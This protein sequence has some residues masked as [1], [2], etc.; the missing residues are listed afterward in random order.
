MLLT[1]VKIENFRGIRKLELGLGETTVLIGE[2]NTG[3]TSILEALHI[4]LSRGLGGRTVPFSEYD[5]HL[6]SPGRDPADAPPI[7]I[8]LTF[9]EQAKDEWSDE[10]TRALGEV[11]QI[12]DDDRQSLMLRITCVY[13]KAVR[14][15]VADWVFLNRE[16]DELPHKQRKLVT[17][18][19][20]LAPVFLL[21]AMRDAS[22]H[23]Q[24]RS[25]FW[26]PFTRNPQIAEDKRKEIEEQIGQINQS[27][28][29]T[30]KP[31]DVVRE[32]LTKTGKFVPL[33]ATDMVSVEA[34]PARIVDM[35]NRTQVKLASPTGA[36]LPIGQ[37]GSGTQSLSVIFLFEAFLQSR[38]ADSYGENAVPILALEEPEAHLHP[39]AIRGIWQT[40]DA[41]A[42]QKVVASHSGDL[43]S[44]V[45]V[46]AIRRL[47]R[48]SGDIMVFKLED[49]TLTQ[50]EENKLTYHVRESR[51][52]LLFAKCWLLVEGETDFW[53]V[54]EFAKHLKHD[55][56]G[57]AVACVDQRNWNVTALLKTARDLGIEWHLLADGDDQ[58]NQDV[59]SARDFL[60]ADPQGDHITQITQLDIE[61]C[62]WDHGYAYVYEKAVGPQQK[63]VI[64]AKK[65]TPD[66]ADQTIKAA[67]KPRGAKL[68]LA[69]EVALEAVG[70]GSPGIPDQIATALE[71]AIKLADES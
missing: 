13:D 32:R 2:N 59:K 6:D 34:V 49:G 9:E 50:T 70:S 29:D 68:A 40:V 57:A 65:G 10:I 15:L 61:H 31:F 46:K 52:S 22:R 1:N 69:Y 41:L 4:C 8:V 36:R 25:D 67:T 21:T 11:L 27:V 5:L 23:F 66:Y 42:G 14:G 38:L 71:S 26:G 3:K 55:L 44:V 28:L 30:H 7:S 51:G 60:G 63:S 18:L 16:G 64:T 54:R 45:P 12:V 20:N 17:D 43:L 19:Q 39:S 58:G 53:I 62:L 24:S 47:A 48:K 33:A 56:D 37:H 35:L